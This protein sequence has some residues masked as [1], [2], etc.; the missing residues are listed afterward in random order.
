MQIQSAALVGGF[1][2]IKGYVGQVGE[3][4]L[5]EQATTMDSAFVLRQI[6]VIQIDSAAVLEQPAAE[7][8]FVASKVY[9]FDTQVSSLH[10]H[11]A[12]GISLNPV[13]TTARNV[14]VLQRQRT[15]QRCTSVIKTEDT[16]GVVAIDNSPGGALYRNGIDDVKITEVVTTARVL[17]IVQRV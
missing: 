15:E 8:C 12:A 10:K 6:D 7:Y 14:S 9:G 2:F 11:T 4:E 5:Q 16:V 3:A 13:S 1:V 17:S